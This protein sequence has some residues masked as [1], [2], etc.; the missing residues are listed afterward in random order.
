MSRWILTLATGI[1]FCLG[2]FA[3]QSTVTAQPPLGNLKKRAKA[4]LNSI[5]DKNELP[6]PP[7]DKNPPKTTGADDLPPPF[8]APKASKKTNVDSMRSIFGASFVNANRGKIGVILTNVQKVSAASQ[9]GLRKGDRLVTVGGSPIASKKDFESLLEVFSLGD[10]TEVE[11]VRDQKKQKTTMVFALREEKLSKKPGTRSGR[12]NRAAR[13]DDQTAPA[14]DF[15]NEADLIPRKPEISRKPFLGLALIDNFQ[16]NYSRRFLRRGMPGARVTSI[17]KDSPAAKAKVPVGSVIVSANGRTIDSADDLILYVQSL[18]PGDE[19]DLKYYQGRLLR[20]TTVSLG[21]KPG[22]KN[23][24]QNELPVYPQTPQSQNSRPRPRVLGDL[25]D[26]FPA[27]KRVEGIVERFSPPPNEGVGNAPTPNSNGLLRLQ[28]QLQEMQSK[29]D[30][31][32]NQIESQ[33][34]RI[35]ELGKKLRAAETKKDS[36]VP[37]R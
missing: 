25:A 31:Q 15:S 23:R 13:V 3:I 34:K 14:S 20:G 29:L 9:A 8:V 33:R 21:S 27:L 10:R 18:N 37:R 6:P 11:Y 17:V 36:G 32:R 16:P 7:T 1:S 5:Q 4:L 19:L 12:S 24:V 35:E 28:Q 22:D 2:G 26:Q 30:A